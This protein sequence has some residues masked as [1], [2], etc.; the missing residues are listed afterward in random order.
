[1]SNFRGLALLSIG[2]A[3]TTGSV[4]R[5]AD[6]EVLTTR[7]VYTPAV[8]VI[9]EVRTPDGALRTYRTA[10]G[11]SYWHAGLPV[12]KGDAVKLNVFV[13]TGGADLAETRVRLD[14]TEIGRRTEAPWNVTLDTGD[15]A[16]GYHSVEAWARTGGDEPRDSTATVVLFVEPNQAPQATTA[17]P[18]VEAIAPPDDAPAPDL[19]PDQGGPAVQLSADTPAAQKA[20]E[21]GARVVVSQPVTFS[22]SG[23]GPDEGFIYA[24]YRGKDEIYRSKLKTVGAKVALRPNTNDVPGLLPGFLRMVVWGSDKQGRLGPPRVIEVDVKG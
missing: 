3:L 2:L 17:S 10:Q 19:A 24:L 7:L 20:L 5:A 8:V 13:S 18:I 22:I 23:P 16:E 6:K 11:V 14:N 21:T 9:P 4:G 15:L 1:M 12:Y